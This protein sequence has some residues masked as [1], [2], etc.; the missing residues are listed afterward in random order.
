MPSHPLNAKRQSDGEHCRQAFRDRGY[1]ER[2]CEDDD[3][4]RAFEALGH[5]A[6]RYQRRSEQQ[7]PA[8][9]L[10]TEAVDTPLERRLHGL[11]VTK[12]RRQ[13]TH[14]ART[15]GS[16]DGEIS[17]SA[18]E[19]CS[20]ECLLTVTLVHGYG[21]AGENGFI[22]HRATGVDQG[23]IG[24]HSVAGLEADHVCRYQ[25]GRREVDEA[26]IS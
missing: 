20:A 8:R 4:W 5:D 10:M 13:A 21:F 18:Y 1:G 12:H 23:A 22:Q 14:R 6:E 11:D 9:D 15:P 17:L 7:D 3:R 19:K 2:D 25:R 24:R 26:T 16:R